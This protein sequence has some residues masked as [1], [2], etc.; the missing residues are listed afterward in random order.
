MN[1]F[2]GIGGI[3]GRLIRSRQRAHPSGFPSMSLG[4]RRVHWMK[5]GRGRPGSM[6]CELR[7]FSEL[8]QTPL[9]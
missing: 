5:A 9:Q 6:F 2:S 4:A 8:T 7:E 1:D 3:V